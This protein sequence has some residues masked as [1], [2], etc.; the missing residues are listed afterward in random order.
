MI[1]WLARKQS[2][3]TNHKL[4][5]SHIYLAC[6]LIVLGLIHRFWDFY[7]SPKNDGECSLI[8][9][10]HSI[11]TIKTN[12]QQCPDNPQNTS[13]T[14]L[15]DTAY[16]TFTF[17]LTIFMLFFN[18]GAPQMKF[19]SFMLDLNKQNYQHVW[20]PQKACDKMGNANCSWIEL[21]RMKKW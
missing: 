1:V 5:I 17:L 8:C 4:F 12:Q 16:T 10:V 15:T 14:V 6:V 18:A 20:M 2:W 19:H 7:R 13:S 9:A 21:P 3:R 11:Y